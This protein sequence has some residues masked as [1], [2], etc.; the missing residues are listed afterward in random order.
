METLNLIQGSPEWHAHRAT[1]RNASDT[2]VVLGVS[3]YR[4]RAQL[5]DERK[6]GI[7]PEISASQQRRFDDGH[8]FEAKA[9]AIAEEIIGEDL[10]PVTGVNGPWSASFDGLNLA[11][12]LPWE[13]K[14]LNDDLR[15]V[16]PFGVVGG[17]EVGACLPIHY[18]AQ[19]EHQLMVCGGKTCLF[20][21]SKWEGDKLIE[22][23]HCMY[24][25][26]PELRER[27]VLA[28]EQFERDLETHELAEAKAEVVG[29]AIQ[30]LPALVVQVE[31]RVVQA[32]LGAFKEAAEQF[33]ASIKTDLVTDQ[34]FAD[35][36]QTVKF[37][38]D[39]EEKLELVKSQ[40]LAQTATIDEL[41][42]TIDH[43][44]EQLRQKRLT[45]TKL[46]QQRKDQIR[47]E[48]AAEASRQLAAHVAELN[49]SLPKPWVTAT[50]VDFLGAM[51][52]L[53]TVASC[54]EK[55]DAALVAAK[56]TASQLAQ[57]YASN[58]AL[59]EPHASLFPDFGLVGAKPKEDF[60]A[61]LELRIRQDE[62]ARKAREA[63]Q[64]QRSEEVPAQDLAP[65]VDATREAQFAAAPSED[66]G[67]RLTLGEISARLGFAVT[68]D[69]MNRMGIQ[70]AG[71]N[72]R[73][74]LYRASDFG[75]ICS[76][77]ISHITKVA[78]EYA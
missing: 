76:S 72:R 4:T 12:D 77:L 69:L 78:K 45:L 19:M 71:T 54:R 41:F 24:Q 65:A 60:Q 53:K 31:G 62:E 57:A 74:V 37:C 22:A 10:Y 36:D 51:K 75:R 52:G 63:A 39:G 14:T 66:D 28:W 34:D 40:V 42:R 49:S 44:K 1:A 29:N 25:S 30:A 13:H 35:A 59:A 67:A 27:I 32:N 6:F 26:D 46:V 61:L 64:A 73:A 16:L 2:P 38:A 50:S 3:P 9:R 56:L 17:P 20:T 11:E 68:Q 21:A 23:R 70:P 5:L 55:V 48:I 15:A 58:W 7:K 47:A 8:A 33:I 43:I 18:R